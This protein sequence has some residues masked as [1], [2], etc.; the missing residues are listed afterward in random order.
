MKK[1]IIKNLAGISFE[2]EKLDSEKVRRIAGAL[3][4]EDLK[5]YIKNLKIIDEKRTVYITIPT[6]EGLGEMRKY[7]IKL[8]PNKKIIFNIDS[9]LLTGVKVVDYDNVYELSL[10]GFLEGA[11]RS[12]N[13]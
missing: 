1:K 5:V 2:N 12:T 3:K 10:K 11:I 13:D 9:S 4:R 6:E 7:F 8:Y